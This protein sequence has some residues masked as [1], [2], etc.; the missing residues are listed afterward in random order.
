MGLSGGRWNLLPYL[1]YLFFNRTQNTSTSGQ[2]YQL[3]DAPFWGFFF[4]AAF[5]HR[6]L[7]PLPYSHLPRPPSPN[8][9]PPLTPPPGRSSLIDTWSCPPPPPPYTSGISTAL[10][11]L[12][13]A[14][15]LGG[16]P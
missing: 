16:R 11:P 6:F 14:V 2:V 5:L 3:W 10:L 7:H 1:D 4:S 12:F 15:P 8:P 9:I 13:P